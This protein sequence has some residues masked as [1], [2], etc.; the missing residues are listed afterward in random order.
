MDKA[1]T[2]NG[3][4]KIANQLLVKICCSNLTQNEIKVLLAIAR[5]SYG[6]NQKDTASRAGSKELREITGLF[7]NQI[8]LVIRNLRYLVSFLYLLPLPV[9]ETY[10]FHLHHL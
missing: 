4:T 8:Y 3:Y 6:W 1:D 5:L 7:T 2:D 9:F 10:S